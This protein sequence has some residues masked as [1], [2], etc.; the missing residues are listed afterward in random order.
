[1]MEDL[2]EQIEDDPDIEDGRYFFKVVM[3]PKTEG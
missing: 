1:M 3:M 2:Q